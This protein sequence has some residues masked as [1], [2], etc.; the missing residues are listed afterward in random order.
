M[1]SNKDRSW[2]VLTRR[3]SKTTWLKKKRF[4]WEDSRDRGIIS[5]KGIVG[6]VEL[7]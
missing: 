2:G 5:D 7:G 4:I 6:H 1:Q 3:S